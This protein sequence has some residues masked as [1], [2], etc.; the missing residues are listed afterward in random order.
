MRKILVTGLFT[1]FLIGIVFFLLKFLIADALASIF[2]PLI[3]D[4]TGDQEYL[5]IPLTVVFTIII[6]LVVGLITTRIHFQDIFNKYFR[7]LP[8]NLEQAR[9]ALVPL[10]SDTY[11]LSI[12]IKEIE[13]KMATGEVENYYVLYSPAAPFPWSGLPVIYAKKIVS[14]Y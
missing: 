2:R 11:V 5:V 14:I 7:K 1:S 9:G 8:K 3:L 13:I 6:I 12:V 10:E 4:I